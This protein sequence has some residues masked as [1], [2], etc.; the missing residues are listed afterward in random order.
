MI[1][2]ITFGFKHEYIVVEIWST[3]VMRRD[4]V[5]YR[6]ADVIYFSTTTFRSAVK[7]PGVSQAASSPRAPPG[8]EL[9]GVHPGRDVPGVWAAGEA[10]PVL[11]QPGEPGRRSVH[12]P[13]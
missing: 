11:Q 3:T 5:L 4:I 1:V 12:G 9:P 7:W 10:V 8:A 6:K 13:Q 2:F